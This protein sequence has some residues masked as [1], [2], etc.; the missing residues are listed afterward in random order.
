MS[1]LTFEQILFLALSALMVTSTLM[2]VQSKHPVYSALYMVLTMFGVAGCFVLLDS[3]FLGVIQVLVYAG[4]IMV[5]FLFILMLLNVDHEANLPP[6]PSIPDVLLTAGF[7]GCLWSLLK[8]VA[9]GMSPWESMVSIFAR[10]H[11]NFPTP[12]DVAWVVKDPNLAGKSHLALD[13]LAS[14]LFTKHWLPFEAI[15]MLLL[16]AILGVVVL[17]K[18]RLD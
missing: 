12:Q 1:S 11:P 18:R 8:A 2:M 17:S 3:F 5:L 6:V 13:N 7:A 4:A 14:T 9:P 15:S 10:N 16:S